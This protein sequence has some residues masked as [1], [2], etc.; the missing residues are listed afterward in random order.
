[1]ERRPRRSTQTYTLFPYTGLFR[2]GSDQA[3]VAGACR[4]ASQ[5]S[6]SARSAIV[7]HGDLGGLVALTRSQKTAKLLAT[8]VRS[9]RALRRF[10]VLRTPLRRDGGSQ[11]GQLLGL[12]RDRKSTRLNSSH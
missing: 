2:S 3:L 4:R 6:A 7:E 9:R 12:E 8:L 1:M 5:A 10:K 11:I